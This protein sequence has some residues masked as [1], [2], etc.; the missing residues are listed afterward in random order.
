L[1]FPGSWDFNS[2]ITQSLDLPIPAGMTLDQYID[3]LIQTALA[4]K[5]L[6]YATFAQTSDSN[7]ENCTT[8]ACRVVHDAGGTVPAWDPWG[9]DGFQDIEDSHPLGTPSGFYAN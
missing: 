8:G 9:F 5:P 7:K 4:D 2:P 6:P 3:K 1:I